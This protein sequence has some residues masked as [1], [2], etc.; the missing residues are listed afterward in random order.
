MKKILDFSGLTV[1]VIDDD[2]DGRAFLSEILR[3]CDATV[4][5]ADNIPAPRRAYV[6]THKLDLVMTDLALPGEDGAMFLKWLRQQPSEGGGTVPA[7]AVTARYE[8]Y[9]PTEVSG[10]AAYFRK[11]VDV[12]HFVQTVAAIL[13]VPIGRT[14]GGT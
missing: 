12:N 5:E 2:E 4:L 3:A 13:N 8:N 14:S 10:W 1:L 7:V 9:P 11:P 6:S